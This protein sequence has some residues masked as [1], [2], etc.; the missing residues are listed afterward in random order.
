MDPDGRSRAWFN[1]AD[2]LHTAPSTIPNQIKI[3][4]GFQRH[5]H[6]WEDVNGDG[7]VDLL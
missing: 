5:E 1:K 6:H 3:S 4:E 2:Q 7:K